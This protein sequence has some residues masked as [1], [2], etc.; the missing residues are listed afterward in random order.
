LISGWFL[1]TMVSTWTGTRK[2]ILSVLLKIETSKCSVADFDYELDVNVWKEKKAR[3]I[4]K[5]E[6]R[7]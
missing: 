2:N 4:Y 3:R 6:S 1:V 5:N 7:Q